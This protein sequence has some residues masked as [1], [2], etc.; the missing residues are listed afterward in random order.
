VQ[1]TGKYNWYTQAVEVFINRGVDHPKYLDTRLFFDRERAPIPTIHI[2]LSGETKGKDGIGLDEGFNPEQVIS[3]SQRPVFNRQFEVNANIVITS[4]NTFETVIIYT[5]MK[6]MLI[7]IMNHI[8]LKGFINPNIS[9]RDITLSQELAPNGIYART[10]NF[11]AGYEHSVP[12]VVLNKIASTV[13]MQMSNVD[14]QDIG[15][16]DISTG[17]ITPDST[18]DNPDNSLPGV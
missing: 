11:T 15:F 18:P 14:N 7:S 13:W 12:E 1:D 16:G 10:I 5:V 2:M 4:D 8:M 3:G 9:G 17:N 6:S